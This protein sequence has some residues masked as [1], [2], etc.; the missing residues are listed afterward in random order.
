MAKLIRGIIR[1]LRPR[2]FICNKVAYKETIFRKG[3]Q[4]VTTLFFYYNFFQ[5]ATYYVLLDRGRKDN[6]YKLIIGYLHDNY[7]R[8]KKEY[9]NCNVDEYSK[10]NVICLM[11]NNLKEGCGIII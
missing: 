5:K 9:L 7:E 3:P 4:M 11:G 10:V 6:H 2:Y 1:I 8:D